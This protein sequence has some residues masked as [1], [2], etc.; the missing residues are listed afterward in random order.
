MSGQELP[1]LCE[2][3][4]MW[5]YIPMYTEPDGTFPHHIANPLIA[6]T[7]ADLQ[8]RVVEEKADIGVAFDGDA[9]R[10]GFID[11]KGRRISEDL[12]TAL[13]AE[14]ILAKEPGAAILYD[15]RSRRVAPET[16][17]RFGG[18]AVR[19]RVGHAF[20]KE[21]MREEDAAFGG[22]LSGHYYHRAMGFTDNAMLTMIQMLNY[23]SLKGEALSRLILPLEEYYSTGEINLR[24]GEREKI[25]AALESR[26]SDA[27]KDYLDGV[28]VEYAPWWFNL[29]ASHT[30]SV[31]RLNLEA[32]DRGLMEE[33]KKE[34]LGIIS[35]ADPSMAVLP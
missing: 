8:K 1:L 16:I 25:F 18:R 14:F 28:T 15:L 29:R 31:L 17:A 13:I 26:Y 11:E 20:I 10:C 4:P 23:L 34:V 33:K 22:E 35:D 21:K 5:E 6:S 27:K 3:M 32:D 30:E 12:I 7:T 9:D 19:S 24:V 2:K